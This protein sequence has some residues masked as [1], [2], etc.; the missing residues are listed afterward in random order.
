MSNK[1]KKDGNNNG[2]W[3]EIEYMDTF[4]EDKKYLH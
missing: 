2:Q 3:N 1:D 4:T